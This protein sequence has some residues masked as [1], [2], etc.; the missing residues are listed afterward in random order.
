MMSRIAEA[1]D[2]RSAAEKCEDVQSKDCNSVFNAVTGAYKKGSGRHMTWSCLNVAACKHG[3]ILAFG[4]LPLGEEHSYLYATDLEMKATVGM[5]K[6]EVKDIA[7]RT[8]KSYERMEKR[9]DFLQACW[10]LNTYANA[11][12]EA[13]AKVLAPYWGTAYRAIAARPCKAFPNRC[14]ETVMKSRL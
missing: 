13:D 11:E 6:V 12:D 1:V 10:K 9:A 7:C 8:A 2:K 14:L 4:R 3:S 5:V